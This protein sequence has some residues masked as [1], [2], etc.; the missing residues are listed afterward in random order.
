MNC[1]CNKKKHTY[2]ID[3]SEV[4]DGEIQKV[5]NF[6]FSGH[7]DLAMIARKVAQHEPL[8]ELHAKEL[9]LGLRLL[10]RVLKENAE[11][12]LYAKLLMHLNEFKHELKRDACC[13][14]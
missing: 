3:I 2:N 12:P 4:V 11:N 6:N 10:H 7:H 9:T 13:G 14:E 1:D 8:C 5:M